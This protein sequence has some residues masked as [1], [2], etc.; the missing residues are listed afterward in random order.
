MQD[1]DGARPAARPL[2]ARRGLD[3][4]QLLAGAAAGGLLAAAGCGTGRRSAPASAVTAEAAAVQAAPTSSCRRSSPGRATSG[5]AAGRAP[6]LSCTAPPE[7][8]PPAVCGAALLG[9]TR[10]QAVPT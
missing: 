1:K 6:S 9:M 5:R 7:V 2:A 10:Q 8:R 3:R 4:R